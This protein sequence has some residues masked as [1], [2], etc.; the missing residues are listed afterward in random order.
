[1]ITLDD[2]LLHLDSSMDD[3]L[4]FYHTLSDKIV[5]INAYHIRMLEDDRLDDYKKN[6]PQWEKESIE[7]VKYFYE[8]EDEYISL[9][10]SFDIDEYDMMNTFAQAY[11]NQNISI[12][13]SNVLIG[14]GAFKR[15]KNTIYDYNIE[16][17]WYQ[18]RDKE[19][20]RIAKEWCEKYHIKY[21]E[22]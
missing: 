8:H 19:Y 22:R 21:Q 5:T 2:V 12:A 17:K 20:K 14:S 4:S 18:Y 11:P 13:L 15:F 7:E 6:C 3:S 16:E 10:S 9:P 1:M